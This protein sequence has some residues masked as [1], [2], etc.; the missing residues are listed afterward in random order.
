VGPH[1]VRGEL[2]DRGDEGSPVDFPLEPLEAVAGLRRLLLVKEVEV[3][4]RQEETASA[5][6]GAEGAV[7]VQLVPD[8][9]LPADREETVVRPD[10]PGA[11]L[12]AEPPVEGGRDQQV[13]GQVCGRPRVELP[14]QLSPKRRETSPRP[15]SRLRSLPRSTRIFPFRS[16]GDRIMPS[17]RRRSRVDS[18]ENVRCEGFGPADTKRWRDS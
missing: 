10:L 2:G 5:R 16:M 9:V 1:L 15:A 13:D 8:V 3:V 17:A 6:G 11:R 4:D 12:S 18:G 14:A 7:L